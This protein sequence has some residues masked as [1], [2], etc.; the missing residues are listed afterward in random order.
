MGFSRKPSGNSWEHVLCVTYVL[1]PA[2]GHPSQ[3]VRDSR[4]TAAMAIGDGDL[5]AL[6]LEAADWRLSAARFLNTSAQGDAAEAVKKKPRV[7]RKKG[8]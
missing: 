8:I 5:A 1:A 4:T 2:L 6:E 7:F 3:V